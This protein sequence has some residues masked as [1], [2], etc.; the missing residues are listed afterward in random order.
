M[1][2][3]EGSRGPVSRGGVAR[4]PL[5][6]VGAVLLGAFLGN[7]DTRLTSV[8]LPD[9]RGGFSLGFDEGAWLSTASIGSQ[10]F[11][12]PSVAWLATVFGLRRVLGSASLLY[13]AISFV[14][15]LVHQYPV[16]ITLSVV[17]GMLL[18][19][20]VPA[21]LMIIFR[22]LPIRWWLPAISIYAIRVGFAF[23]TSQSAVGF[24]V[25]HLGW[26]WLYW[27]GVFIAPLM[28]LLVYLGT[29]SEP[30]N[31][32]LLR[33]AD[34]G[35]MLL[36]GTAVSMIY[37][38]LDQGNRLDWLASGTVVA[39]LS[40]GGVLLICFVINELLAKEPWAHVNVVFSRN[41]GLGLLG[42]VL[43]T[44]TGLANST[45]VPNFLVTVGGLRPEQIGTLLLT[46][47]A[48]PMI[49]LVPLSIW[50]LRHFDP[51][52]VVVLGFS[53]FG[54][55]NLLATQLTHD[56]ARGDFVIVVVLLSI[57]QALTLLPII[58]T[59]LSN[60]DPTRATAFAA[61]IQVTRLGGSEIGIALIGTW[62][63]V[64]EQVHSYYLGVHVENGA[65]DVTQMLK[66]FSNYFAGDDAGSASARAV[67]LLAS[68]VQRE[69]N[70]LAY[71]D[72]FW[73]CF[74]GAIAGLVVTACMTRAP[75]GPFTPEPFGFAKIVL[76]RCGFSTS[77]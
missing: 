19:T 16:L 27:Q 61:Y 22:N 69:A 37:A 55:A 13:A 63:R 33:Y 68:L 18:G 57:G 29:P 28:A 3:N 76:R 25:E 15:P 62:L 52:T 40:G 74:W 45:L 30:V 41:I 71:I 2:E 42:I 39:L 65:A 73:L 56:W 8:G 46:Y 12:A 64:R 67:D 70:V 20:F 31:R 47:G 5:F 24:Y 4:Y 54:A 1:A 38:G 23:D 60:S 21:T 77:T 58:I 17:H 50:L 49:V 43:Y 7:F 14:I 66:Q 48:L 26:Q 9:L 72:G 11:I 34:W 36:L 6:A 53:A 51:R 75:P 35:G 44:L 10:I 59:L 32:H